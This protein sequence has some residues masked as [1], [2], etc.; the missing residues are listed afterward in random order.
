MKKL[1][2]VLVLVVILSCTFTTSVFAGQ[3]PDEAHNGLERVFQGEGNDQSWQG[4]Y[5]GLIAPV[6]YGSVPNHV[7]WWGPIWASHVILYVLL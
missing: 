5:Q 3:P 1:I 2:L 4:L 7:T 6:F